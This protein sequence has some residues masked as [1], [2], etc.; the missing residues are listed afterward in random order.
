MRKLFGTD[1]I[2]GV[3]NSE[4]TPEIAYRLGNA[5]AQMF[6]NI[7][8]ELIIARDTRLS[9]DL[10]ESALASGAAAG[11]MKVVLAGVATTPALVMLTKIKNTVGVMI[12]A[13]HNPPE[14][15]GLKVMERG[16]KI[17]D[18]IEEKLERLME[19]T[20]LVAPGSVKRIKNE[21]ELIDLYVEK[22]VELYKQ[23]SFKNIHIAVD[24]ANGGAYEIARKV[25]EA[26]GISHEIFFNQPDG[27]NI[28][29]GCGSTH[30]EGLIEKTQGRS[31]DAGVLFDGDA[32]RCLMITRNGKLVDGDRLITL[33]AL[34]MLKEGRLT[35][36]SVVVTIMSNFGMER[37]LKSHGIEV[38]RTKV[39]DRY[40][41]E[42]MLEKGINLGGEQSGHIIFLDRST[43]GDGIITSLETLVSLMETGRDLADILREVPRYPQKLLNVK[44]NRKK[45]VAD[46]PELREKL[47][48]LPEDV[49][50]VVRPSGTEPLIRI[51][52]EG[53]NEEVVENLS[54]NLKKFIEELILSMEEEPVP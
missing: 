48:T 20:V 36:R 54:K 53:E 50:V 1:G 45:E 37:Y 3:V 26:L 31:F 22:I 34:K 11:G 33:N 24:T 46:S 7:H 40:V 12:S 19:K 4:L 9:G 13:S 49:R 47:K 21:P 38:I 51:M 5:I 28:N 8:S 17:S 10:L 14:Y 42:T 39:G 41:L 29:E 15:N 25:Y 23:Y 2:R 16:Y 27:R 6:G 35:L 52:V 43:T 44:T 18:S 30:P 32:D